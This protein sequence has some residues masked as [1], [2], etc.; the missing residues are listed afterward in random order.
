MELIT[1]LIL[2]IGG[3]VVIVVG[4]EFILKGASYIAALLGIRPMV[5]GL[6]VVS[7]GT[8]A[9]ELAVGITAVSQN[10]PEIAIGNI[11]GT[12]LV[13]LLLILGLSAAIRPLPLQ[14]MSIRLDVPVMIFS[15]I[16]IIIMALN[17]NLSR[18]EGLILFV[19]A[20]I[21]TL[22]LL[23]YSNM[24]SWKLKR[25]YSEEYS[26]NVLVKEKKNA[27]VVL[28]NVVFLFGGIA[29]AIVG[30]NLLVSGASEIAR[31]LGVSEA[32]IALTI[33]AIGTSAPELV[34]TMVAT[35]KN[36][37]D[38]AIGNLIGSSIYNILIILGVTAMVSKNGIT[39]SKQLLMIDL[40]LAAIVAIACYPVF[41]TSKMV[42]RN[43]GIVFVACYVLYITTLL[44]FRT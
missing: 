26:K 30:S 31:N 37:R 15:A 41:K 4:A 18:V 21:Y 19:L 17:G 34:T 33:V 35:F 10:S 29:L 6:T 23:R 39:V 1:S 36:D 25:E 5:I 40:P 11:A 43:E 16:L 32:V 12:N 8:S 27:W 42:T 20:I 28:K 22:V 44:I 14:R 13:N 7:L 24:E 3:L 38:V 9:P 2:F